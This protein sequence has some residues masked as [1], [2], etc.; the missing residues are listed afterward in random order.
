MS[1]LAALE[2]ERVLADLRELAQLTGDEHGAQR[3]AWSPAWTRAREWLRAKLEPITATQDEAGNLW[4][5]LPG[6]TPDTVLIGS[7][8]DSVP[9]GGRLDGCLGVLAALEIMRAAATT[10]TRR[11]RTLALVDW[12]D[13]EGARF[14]HSLYG[15]EAATGN[16]D[17]A[18]LAALRDA[19][20]RTA[21]DVLREHGIELA[22]A[23]RARARIAAVIA[24]LELHIE[25]GP[26]LE[27][28]G[29]PL[30][31]PSGTLAVERRAL[32]LRG[33]AAHAG[34][35]PMGAARRDPLAAAARVVLAAREAARDDTR[36]TVGVL[37]PLPATP[38]AVPAEVRMTVDLRAPTDAA[39][40]QLVSALEQQVEMIAA[41][42]RVAPAWASLWSIPAISFDAE[43]VARLQRASGPGA[44]RLVSGAL[45]DSAN[46][47]RAGVPAAMLFVA[48]RGGISHSPLEESADADVIA[49]VRALARVAD[50]LL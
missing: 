31:V 28:A 22:A 14:G 46:L 35:T 43:L 1:L 17:P 21:A 40:A 45:H 49:G 27:A 13:E 5:A 36:A 26:V 23:P 47:A 7:H 30:G 4:A 8:L 38:T 33:A 16:L 50:E 42:E 24:A 9:G 37:T 20:G 10:A 32:T 44:P 3:L 15:S 2:P 29:V 39:L 19:D 18:A 48:S 25:Q 41:Q 11:E 6:A 34:S 12:A